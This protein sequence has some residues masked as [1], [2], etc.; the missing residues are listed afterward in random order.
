MQAVAACAV[1]HDADLGGKLYAEMGPVGVV[2]GRNLTR[3]KG[4]IGAEFT[5]ADWVRAIRYG[6]G[7]MAR[8]SS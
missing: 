1:C 6:V 2:A 5:D 8:R 3:G 4:G 7:A